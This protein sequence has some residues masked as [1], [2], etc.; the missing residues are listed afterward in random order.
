MKWKTTTLCML[1]AVLFLAVLAGSLTWTGP[2]DATGYTIESFEDDFIGGSDI[3][4]TVDAGL[5]SAFSDI[6][7]KRPAATGKLTIR[8]RDILAPGGEGGGF[9]PNNGNAFLD[10]TD[11]GGTFVTFHFS[12]GGPDIVAGSVV[13]F[14]VIAYGGDGGSLL[15]YTSPDGVNFSQVGN[16]SSAIGEYTF[17]LPTVGSD[18]YFRL[19]VGTTGIFEGVH[20]DNISATINTSGATPKPTPTIKPTPTPG[21]PIFV[22]GI[23]RPPDLRGDLYLQDSNEATNLELLATI[24]AGGVILTALVWVVSWL[25]WRRK[26]IG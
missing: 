3:P 7:E 13:R 5:S 14:Y 17:N 21:P 24:F 1:G 4:N 23:A 26:A 19:Q 16:A 11:G 20:I 25:V 12:T 2:A 18:A 9:P 8:D 6:N 22:G 10:F 15:K